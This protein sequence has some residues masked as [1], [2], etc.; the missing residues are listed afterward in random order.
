[1]MLAYRTTWIVKPGRMQEA[2]ELLTAEVNR[3]KPKNAVV[4]IYT[5]NISPNVLVF[6]EVWE[7]TEMHDKVWAEYNQDPKTSAFRE[8]SRE[9]IER[10]IGTDRW[11]VTELR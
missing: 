5:P 10:I 7:S 3:T 2:L 1:M 9:V 11:N 4:R 8:K 6:E